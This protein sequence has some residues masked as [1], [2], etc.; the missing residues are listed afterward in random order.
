MVAS[1]TVLCECWGTLVRSN[2]CWVCEACG[3]TTP[4]NDPCDLTEADC[5]LFLIPTVKL[6]ALETDPLPWHRD[7]SERD[8][9]STNEDINPFT[10][11]TRY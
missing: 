11:T 2:D 3:E 4:V 7:R 8:D 6:T 9:I 10:R 5:D 1:F